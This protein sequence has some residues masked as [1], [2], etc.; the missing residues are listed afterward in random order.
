MYIHVGGWTLFAN[1]SNNGVNISSN[2]LTDSPAMLGDME[3][4]K[5]VALSYIGLKIL[6]D[7]INAR[8]F[9]VY[10]KK[11]SC[12]RTIHVSTKDN[13]NGHEVLGFF[14]GEVNYLPSCLNSYYRFAEDT[15]ELTNRCSE[16]KYDTAVWGHEKILSREKS[17]YFHMMYIAK[18]YH[19]SVMEGLC[20]DNDKIDKAGLWQYFVR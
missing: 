16:W 3:G 4:G 17:I 12:P 20:D 19:V 7:A 15:S 10:C 11:K 1:L 13:N 14:A 6:K 18:K 2:V 9:R 5:N 8:Q